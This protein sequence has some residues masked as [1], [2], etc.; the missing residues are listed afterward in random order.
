M[1]NKSRWKLLIDADIFVFRHA[2][3]G[4]QTIRWDEDTVSTTELPFPVVQRNFDCSIRNLMVE[5]GCGS[6]ALCLTHKLNFRYA[7]LPSYKG[8]RVK[9][10]PVHRRALVEHC[11][12]RHPSLQ[13]SECEADD[14]IG[15]Y[16]TG[17]D[18][19]RMVVASADK[20][21]LQIPGRHYDMKRGCFFSVSQ[22]EGEACFLRQWLTGDPTDGYRGI[23]GFGPSK[24]AFAL[25]AVDDINRCKK[26]EMES[27]QSLRE[28]YV[29]K[30][31]LE[32]HQ[33]IFDIYRAYGLTDEECLQ[34]A[35]V[36]RILRSV[37][38]N[39]K[40]Q[41]VKLWTPKGVACTI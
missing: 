37:D 40:A 1:Q 2:A 19:D 20:D 39:L 13:L 32:M 16:A 34:Q 29:G 38:Y 10:D 9:E 31:A 7:V 6:Y 5:S 11:L 3:V 36:A 28:K 4:Q 35:R 23:P 21:L 15:I 14:V 8:N 17:P 26:K 18:A 41:R 33:L 27:L 25:G 12:K 24:A 22:E 30:S